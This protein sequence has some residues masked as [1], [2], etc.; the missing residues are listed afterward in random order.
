MLFRS[1]D[2]SRARNVLL[3]VLALVAVVA[4]LWFTGLLDSVLP[5]RLQRQPPAACA[6]RAPQAE[7]PVS[8]VSP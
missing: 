2:D 3:V 6:L 5:R 4:A 1:A 8:A 7:S